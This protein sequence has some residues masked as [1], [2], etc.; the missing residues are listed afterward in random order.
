MKRAFP[1]LGCLTMLLGGCGER[2]R[3]VL[4]AQFC[5][6]GEHGAADFEREVQAIARDEGMDFFSRGDRVEDLGNS[7]QIQ[8]NGSNVTL[9]H[10]FEV[11]VRNFDDSDGLSA[12]LSGAPSNQVMMGFTE[13]RDRRVSMAFARRVLSRLSR[14]WNVRPVSGDVGMFP[15]K[16]C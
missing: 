8:H 7:F 13:G 2:K 4:Q 14:T 1:V 15:L 16:D 11:A 9:P 10:A 5:L 3:P 12:N 6:T